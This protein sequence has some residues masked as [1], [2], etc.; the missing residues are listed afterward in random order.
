[1]L[2]CLDSSATATRRAL[3]DL[4]SRSTARGQAELLFVGD[5]AVAAAGPRRSV[6]AVRL[7]RR[8]D[9]E[10]LASLYTIR[11]CDVINTRT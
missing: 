9:A 3:L 7:H 11:R 8:A 2:C 6:I 10:R 5:E 4:V 1:M